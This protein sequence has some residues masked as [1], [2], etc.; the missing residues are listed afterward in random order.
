MNNEKLTINNEIQVQNQK[1]D[2]NQD[3]AAGS[4]IFVSVFRF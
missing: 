1:E 2:E 4:T 3:K